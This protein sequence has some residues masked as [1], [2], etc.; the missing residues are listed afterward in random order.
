MSR[1]DAP[2]PLPELE[3]Q[4]H[5]AARRLDAVA[6]PRR[7]RWWRGGWTLLSLLLV[8]TGGSVAVARVVEV[9]PFAYMSGGIVGENPK[10]APVST[11][12]LQPPGDAPAWQARAYLNG[13]DQLCITGGPRDPRKDPYARGTEKHPNNAPQ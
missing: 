7:R 2:T 13:L 9:G 8:V 5:A 3:R 1:T 4:L 6:A 10:A 11:I 12:T